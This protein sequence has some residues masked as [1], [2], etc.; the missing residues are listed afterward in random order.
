MNAELELGEV[1]VLVGVARVAVAAIE[2]PAEGAIRVDEDAHVGVAA[3][4][5]RTPIVVD[6]ANL[7]HAEVIPR[8]RR[9]VAWTR[10]A[11]AA[12]V[13]VRR[14]AHAARPGAA[15]AAHGRATHAYPARARAARARAARAR[16]TGARAAG[17]DAARRHGTTDAGPARRS[18]TGAHT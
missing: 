2:R 6:Q 17:A 11:L 9:P 8:G 18:S 16:A 10:V 4:V 13:H 1:R 14:A 3:E 15:R 5:F 12:R 7:A